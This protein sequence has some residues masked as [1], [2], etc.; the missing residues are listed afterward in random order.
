M[1]AAA[2]HATR[3][4]PPVPYACAWELQPPRLCHLRDV[5]QP[6]VRRHGRRVRVDDVQAPSVER[7]VEAQLAGVV[8]K[9]GHQT[10]GIVEQLQHH[11]R[12]VGP[13]NRRTRRGL[14]FFRS[15]QNAPLRRGADKHT[16]V[17]DELALDGINSHVF[18][19]ADLLKLRL[20]KVA[21][22][23]TQAVPSQ[24]PPAGR[25]AGGCRGGNTRSPAHLC[26][27]CNRTVESA[28]FW[29]PLSSAVT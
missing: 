27:T 29:I 23:D 3:I 2:G 24:T 11:G 7:G 13:C 26:D 8:R 4:S 12:G 1:S 9:R 22:E 18:V 28:W 10:I 20:A 16:C 15:Q 5:L 21:A 17:G 14:L 19:Q 25:D 6:S